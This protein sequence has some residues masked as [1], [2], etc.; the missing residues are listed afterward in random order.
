M[1]QDEKN[2][3]LKQQFRDLVQKAQQNQA[4]LE[5]FQSFEQ[6]LLSAQSL[7]E[8]IDVLLLKSYLHFDLS[9]CRL[10]WLEE[11]QLLRSLLPQEIRQQFGHRLVFSGMRDDIEQ[12]FSHQQA[13]ILKALT[14][15][16]KLHWFPGRTHVESAAFI[17]LICRG[18]LLGCLNL[19]SPEKLRFSCDKAVDFM[20]HMGFISAI[21]LQNMSAQE[22]LR[23]LS[24][25]DNL[26]K[27][28]NRR[29]FDKDIQIEIAR[30]RRSSQPLSCLFLDADFFKRIND[31]YGH[32]AGDE[33]LCSLAKWAQTQ[34]R[35]TDHI[36]R[37]GGEEFVIL[38]PACDEQ[39]AFEIAERIRHYVASQTI[40][41][42]KLRLQMTLSIGVCT[43]NPE[44]NQSLAIEKVIKK[45]LGQADAGV[46]MAK[47]SGRNRV[48]FKAFDDMDAAIVV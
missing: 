41:F 11:D 21:C 45:L 18:Q 46:Y 29:S 12:L 36:A 10:L 35:E 2:Q 44:K 24:L 7:A 4:V 25:L 30:S 13:P 9:D 33:A 39:M 47:E 19:A 28:K 34:L 5:R 23:R 48:C 14:P 27:V 1:N 22:Q 43:Y 20:A 26:T 37:F 38:L 15:T 6:L 8:L 3:L 31:N 16:E 40:V 32:Q 17:P 42:E